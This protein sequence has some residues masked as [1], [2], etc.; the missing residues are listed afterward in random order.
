MSSLNYF[1]LVGFQQTTGFA[2]PFQLDSADFGELN[3]DRLGGIEMVDLT[4]QVTS[5]GITR[6][7]NRETDSFNA[8]TAQVRFRDPNRVLDP[9][10]EDSPYYP[11]VTPRQ[12]IQ[13]RASNFTTVDKSVA[14]FTGVITDW[15]LEYDYT[16]NGNVMV[17]QCADSFTVLANQSM[18]EWTPTA[19]PSGDRIEAVLT[20]PEIQYQ[21]GYNI[22]QSW[23]TLGAYQ[24]SLGTN[25]L[26]YLQLVTASEFGYLFMDSESTLTFKGRNYAVNVTGGELEF[27]EDGAGIRYQAL[28][29]QF[30][31]ELLF[32]YVQ[33]QSPAGAAQVASDS[34][35]IALYQAQQY[36]KTD[37][38]NST[39]S[40]V[41]NLANLFLGLHKDPLFRFTGVSVLVEDVDITNR[42]ELLGL[43]LTDSIVVQKSYDVG[44]PASVEKVVLVSGIEHQITPGYHVIKYTVENIDQRAYFELDSAI[45]GVL[46]QNLLAF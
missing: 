13:I 36:N 2:T 31:D 34:T 23:S 33:M 28:T 42:Q 29:N 27:R 12:P 19:Q 30:G 21:G 1:V 4:A 32:N 6:G 37:L 3:D 40:E 9:L 7:R 43:D 8:G 15:N 22:G 24:V 46:D 11:F 20:R 38:L 16:T 35:S 18:A 39:T 25:V 10:N 26:N 45:L 44:S 41:Q 5:I 17:A 14:L